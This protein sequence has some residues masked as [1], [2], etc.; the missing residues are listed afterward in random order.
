[1]LEGLCPLL[2]GSRAGEDCRQCPGNH[3]SHGCCARS[4]HRGL[5]AQYRRGRAE[6][7]V[8]P[9]RDGVGRRSATALTQ[10]TA[11]AIVSPGT[12]ET[13][14]H[15]H[16]L[17]SPR[18][19]RLLRPHW[20]RAPGGA[21]PRAGRLPVRR[22][23]RRSLLRHPPAGPRG[24]PCSTFPPRARGRGWRASSAWTSSTTGSTASATR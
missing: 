6:T 18:H 20:R 12:S 13:R 11:D 21:S 8:E 5:P 24:V 17:H 3:H 23:D 10:V 9:V 15:G 2:G 22:L 1:V 16:E 19:S 7:G 14:D 4:L